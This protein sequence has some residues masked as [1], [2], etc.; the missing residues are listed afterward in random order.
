PSRAKRLIFTAETF[1]GERALEW[2]IVDELAD[3][4]VAHAHALAQ[5]IA[6]RSRSALVWSKKLVGMA[7]VESL[8]AGLAAE[9]RALSELRGTEEQRLAVQKRMEVLAARRAEKRE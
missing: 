8:E 4:A 2:G 7:G 6:D 3:D 5:E 1:T 9:Q